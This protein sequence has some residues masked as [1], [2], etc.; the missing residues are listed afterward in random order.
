MKGIP[1]MSNT[2]LLGGNSP[3]AKTLLPGYNLP[4]ISHH[5]RTYRECRCPP[6]PAPPISQKSDKC[7]KCRNNLTFA[8]CQHFE[9]VL[10]EDTKALGEWRA[11]WEE[12]AQNAVTRSDVTPVGKPAE[13]FERD[14]HTGPTKEDAAPSLYKKLTL[15]TPENRPAEVSVS[16]S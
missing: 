13:I 1:N 8:Y 16:E 15:E 4:C 5:P 7:R 6:P 10:A 2:N 9:S 3:K 12:P 14:E 11:M